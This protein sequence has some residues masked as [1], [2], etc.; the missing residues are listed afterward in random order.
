MMFPPQRETKR[1]ATSPKR[2]GFIVRTNT[3]S[4]APWWAA[5]LRLLAQNDYAPEGLNLMDEFS[6]NFRIYVE[7]FDGDLK[8]VTVESRR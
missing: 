6:D 4:V 8:V 3:K 1:H 5:K 2:F 7:A